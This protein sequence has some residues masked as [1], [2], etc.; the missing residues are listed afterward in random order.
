MEADENLGCV[1]FTSLNIK[2]YIKFKAGSGIKAGEGIKADWGIKAGL[3]IEADYISSN[4][5]IFTGLCLGKTQ[6]K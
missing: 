2:Y 6:A 1:K 4:L 3:G 5:G